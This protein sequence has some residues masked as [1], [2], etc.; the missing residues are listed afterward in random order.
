MFDHIDYMAKKFGADYIAIGSDSAYS[1]MKCEAENKKFEKVARK[2]RA[3]WETLWP[4]GSLRNDLDDEPS[5]SWTNWPLFTVGL[6][7]RGYSDDDIR[8]IIGGNVM[9]VI[10]KAKV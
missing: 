9:R 8:K 3:S 6:V 2:T 7:Q 10:N 4:E 1:S 5:L